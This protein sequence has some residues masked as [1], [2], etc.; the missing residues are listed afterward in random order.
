MRCAV[1]RGTPSIFG[2]HEIGD[3]IGQQSAGNAQDHPAEHKR[4]GIGRDLMINAH[5]RQVAPIE[6]GNVPHPEQGCAGPVGGAENGDERPGLLRK[7][8]ASRAT[9]FHPNA[10]AQNPTMII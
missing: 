3:G 5:E 10:Q 2:E 4:P 7:A 8:P 6:R 1:R 9:T